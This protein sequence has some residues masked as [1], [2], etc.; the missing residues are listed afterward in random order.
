M[1][2]PILLDFISNPS[3]YFKNT[4]KAN[5]IDFFKKM[6]SINIVEIMP[7]NIFWFKIMRI[8]GVGRIEQV[9]I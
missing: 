3:S 7:D 6:H 4:Y 1:F 9:A 5:I 8:V 2:F